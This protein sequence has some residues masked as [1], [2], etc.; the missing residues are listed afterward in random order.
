M[1][2]PARTHIALSL[3]ACAAGASLFLG[4]ATMLGY[5]PRHPLQPYATVAGLWCAHVAPVFW[6]APVPITE[7][8]SLTSG[9]GENGWAWRAATF[10][11]VYMAIAIAA[12]SAAGLAGAAGGEAIGHAVRLAVPLAWLPFVASRALASHR[13]AAAAAAER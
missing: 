13:A 6:R 7:T 2:I 5:D 1:S 9:P 10:I 8:L 11:G 12:S 4:L 3:L